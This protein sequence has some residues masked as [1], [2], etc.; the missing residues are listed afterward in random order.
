[1]FTKADIE[2]YF[3]AEKS[4]SLLFLIIGIAAIIAA[5][6]CYFFLKTNFYKGMAVPFITIGLLL[7]IVGYTVYARSD[8]DRIR[9][10]YAYDMNPSELKNKEIPRMEKVIKNFV[11][12]RYTEII[13]ALTGIILFV[14]YKTDSEKTFWKGLGLSLALMALVALAADYFAEKRARQYADGLKNWIENITKQL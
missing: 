12:Y 9:N 3:N 14:Y 10:A 13:L 6:T 4:E 8:N 11:L 5:V 1:M 2:K 7:G